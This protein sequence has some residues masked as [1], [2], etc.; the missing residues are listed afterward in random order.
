MYKEG[1]ET[2]QKFIC[3]DQTDSRTFGDL[4]FKEI[5]AREVFHLI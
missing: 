2:I 3:G 4:G 1:V 5:Q